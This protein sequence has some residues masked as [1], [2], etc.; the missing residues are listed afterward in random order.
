M[1]NEWLSGGACKSEDLAPSDVSHLWVGAVWAGAIPAVLL[2]FSRAAIRRSGDARAI[3][4][5]PCSETM[6]IAR[7]RGRQKRTRVSS[8]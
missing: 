6:P 7:H 3:R 4:D 8:C 5:P 1:I 2:P